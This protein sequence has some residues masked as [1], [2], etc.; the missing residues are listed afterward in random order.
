MGSYVLRTSERTILVDT[1]LG[2]QPDAF[3]GELRGDL[4][5]HLALADFTP[6]DF[7]T[8]FVTH[9]HPDQ[10]GWNLTAEG[11]PTFPNARYVMSATDW[12][13]FQDPEVQG[14]LPVSFVERT[15]TPSSGLASST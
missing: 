14:A 6:E 7:D 8:V 4:I 11:E 12:R 3:F 10:V 5:N 2:P 1:G 15:L 9:A 13:T